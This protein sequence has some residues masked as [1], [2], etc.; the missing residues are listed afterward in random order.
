MLGVTSRMASQEPQ[1]EL[2]AMVRS[3]FRKG[4]LREREQ[5]KSDNQ[6]NVF[7]KGYDRMS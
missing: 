6:L 3:E 5:I 4:F 2:T 7:K 1:T